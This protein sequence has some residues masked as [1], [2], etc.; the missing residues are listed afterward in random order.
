MRSFSLLQDSIVPYI[1]TLIGQLTHKLLLVS[2]VKKKT[3]NGFVCRNL[4][5]HRNGHVTQKS[6]FQN[7]SK[8]HF[9]HY[10]FESLCLSIRITCKASPVAVSSFE[11]ALFPVFT[12][13]LQNDVQGVSLLL[14]LNFLMGHN[15]FMTVSSSG[16]F[17]RVSSVRVPGDVSPSRDPL[18]LYSLF[19]HGFISPPAPACPVGEDREHPPSGAAPPGFPGEGGFIYFKRRCR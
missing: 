19:L 9:N 7:P 17:G 1:P 6:A 2:K 11:E 16:F 12:E 5:F 18:Q 10:L 8:P 13:I 4:F 14:V 15:R 3:L